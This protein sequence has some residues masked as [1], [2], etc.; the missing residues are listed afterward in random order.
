MP[1]PEQLPGCWRA[2]GVTAGPTK[3][4]TEGDWPWRVTVCKNARIGFHD[5]ECCG[6]PE[7][8]CI[9]ILIQCR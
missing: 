5:A 6:E 9:V 1:E 4:V 8:L 7:P 2:M 3:L